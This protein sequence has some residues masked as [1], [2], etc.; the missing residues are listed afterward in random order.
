VFNNQCA[1]DP[2]HLQLRP[3]DLR[4]G[5]HA[6]GQAG[7]RIADVAAVRGVPDHDPIR[8]KH[9][10]VV[11]HPAIREAFLKPASDDIN[12]AQSTLA[13]DVVEEIRRE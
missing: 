8:V 10:G 11:F 13:A 7:K 2:E 12:D 5:H 6:A 3:A 9:G 1:A 4:V